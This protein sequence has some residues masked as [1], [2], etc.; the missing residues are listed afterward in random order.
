VTDS[1][2][3]I[4]YNSV[5]KAA[6]GN[7]QC[8]TGDEVTRLELVSGVSILCCTLVTLGDVRSADAD[9]VMSYSF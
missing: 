5:L 4:L 1:C 9:L 7:R 6:V 3:L 2:W 8:F